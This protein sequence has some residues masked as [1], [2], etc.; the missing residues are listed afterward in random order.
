ME[1]TI[2]EAALGAV[3]EAAAEKRDQAAKDLDDALG[4]LVMMVPTF[5]FEKAADKFQIVE[6]K[7]EN[8]RLQFNLDQATR[9]GGKT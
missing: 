7:T 1:R 5:N 2:E 8:A 6:L 9:Q 3:L 4:R